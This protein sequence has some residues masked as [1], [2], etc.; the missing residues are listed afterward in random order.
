MCIY[1]IIGNDFSTIRGGVMMC[2]LGLWKLLKG[3]SIEF[4]D[5]NIML[6]I[7]HKLLWEEKSFWKD[8]SYESNSKSFFCMVDPS[9]QMMVSKQN[10]K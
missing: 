2:L 6:R 10:C 5:K 9:L 7:E 3:Q 4:H 1:E 8:A